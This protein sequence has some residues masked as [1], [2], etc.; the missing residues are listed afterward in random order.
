M[1]GT[2]TSVIIQQLLN[3]HTGKIVTLFGHNAN[4][5]ICMCKCN[6]NCWSN[7]PCMTES[8]KVCSQRN[9][10][11]ITYFVQQSEEHSM[12]GAA[13]KQLIEANICR[14]RH[15]GYSERRPRVARTLIQSLLLYA[16]HKPNY[17]SLHN[18]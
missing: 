11:V 12:H 3:C 4:A 13:V 17:L 10:H 8:R 6:L 2:I 7:Y 15:S 16:V 18:L 14:V 9:H 5:L 1:N